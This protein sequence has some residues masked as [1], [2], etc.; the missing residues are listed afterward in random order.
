MTDAGF[1]AGDWGTSRLRLFLC[2]GEGLV[3]E[4]AD[5]AGAA[6]AAGRFASVFDRLVAPWQQRRGPLP[7]VL[8]GMVGSS[9]GWV[10]APYVPCPSGPEQIA[11]ACVALRGGSIQVVPG[12][13]CRNRLGAP[14]F[15]RGEETQILGAL[16]IDPTLRHGQRLLCLPGTHTKWVTLHDG[17]IVEFLTAPTGELFALLRDHSVLVQRDGEADAVSGDAAFERALARF[18]AYPQAQLL[19]L[20]FECRAR[21]L[22]GELTS[23]AATAYLSGL[24]IASDIG[25]A[26]RLLLPGGDA[27]HV[28][29]IGDPQLTRL[30]AL[31]LAAQHCA[32][33]ALE[34]GAAALAGLA[35]V[36]RQLGR[37]QVVNAVH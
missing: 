7:A 27:R 20:L 25:G 14:D 26:L 24:L 30:Y 28:H 32:T 22:S 36:H 3:L 6:E 19:H 2:D 4:R 16:N 29:L 35:Q 12:M 8:C 5:A 1:I 11:A 31:A 13:S 34:G 33:S 37:S 15:M 10:T 21:R 18:S 23:Q 17:V 9:I